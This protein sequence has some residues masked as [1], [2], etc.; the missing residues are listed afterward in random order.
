MNSYV[1][2][3]KLSLSLLFIYFLGF[4]LNSLV[5]LISDDFSY[6]RMGLDFSSRYQHY[7][8]WSGRVEADLISSTILQFDS[9]I[10]KSLINTIPLVALC[11]FIHKIISLYSKSDP[12]ITV[13]ITFSC[14]FLFNPNLGQTTFWI[15]GAANYLWTT[16]FC[17]IFTYSICLLTVSD[18][19]SKTKELSIYLSAILAGCSSEA[20]AAL[21]VSAAAL[22]LFYNQFVSNKNKRI[23]VIA[24]I[25]CLVGFLVLIGAPGNKIRLASDVFSAWRGMGLFEKLEYH[26]FERVPSL[27][28]YIKYE[29]TIS[30]LCLIL[31]LF[32]NKFKFT[33]ST[34]YLYIA[35]II[36]FS[37]IILIL[38]LSPYTPERTVNILTVILAIPICA[39]INVLAKWVKFA[40]T[41]FIVI[42]MVINWS[43][44]YS[45]YSRVYIQDIM[46]RVYMQ[47]MFEKDVYDI[48]LPQYNFSNF[49]KEFDLWDLFNNEYEIARYFGAN[50]VNV[51]PVNV[52][53]SYLSIQPNY[54][55]KLNEGTSQEKKYSINFYEDTFNDVLLIGET[56]SSTGTLEGLTQVNISVDTND[57][58][59]QYE[60]PS[61][62]VNIFDRNFVVV[63]TPKIEISKSKKIAFSINSVDCI[64]IINR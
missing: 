43:H 33:A 29:L 6:M 35:P 31:F 5:P 37:F 50:K 15:V 56:K 18:R 13:L 63:R 4:I 11:F 59:F 25:L 55:C 8:T 10:I 39:L 20:S 23:T 57:E 53:Y 9:T 52:D 44:V 48:T 2:K 58:T 21:M 54:T 64:T 60:L 28:R 47:E 45:S 7:M 12:L 19:I 34:F 27:L 46:R 62:N 38:T 36:G 3:Y 24:F 16:T 17:I 1:N 61:N 42:I 32:K 30:L 22:A 49:F 40:V 51:V 41:Y 26:F 14:Y